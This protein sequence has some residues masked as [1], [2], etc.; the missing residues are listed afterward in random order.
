MQKKISILVFILF[1]VCNAANAQMKDPQDWV[2]YEDVMGVKNGLQHYDYNATLIES[3]APANVFWPGDNINLKF[4]LEN[5]THQTIETDAKIYVFRYGTKGIPNDI[6][7]PQIVKLDYEKVIPARITIS[8]NGYTNTS[9]SID[10][11]KRYGGYAVV[12]D[13]GKYGRR[14]GTSF[15]Y[16]MKP[17]PVKMQYPKQS[18]D[19]LGVD[20][21]SRVGIQS[22]CH[23]IPYVSTASADY[24]VFMQ[25][26]AGLMKKYMDNNI[27]VMLMFGEGRVAPLMPLGTSRPH[28]DESNTFLRTKQDLVWLP[29]MDEDFKKYVKELC[30]KFGWPNGPV[31]A[32]CLWNEPW[33]G[34]SI[35]G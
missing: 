33:E 16:S 31:T 10:D 9:I 21:L 26:F 1:I 8:P 19:D 18:L 3:T 6:W 2:G 28:L 17:S 29:Q 30:L 4:Q 25:D 11:I 20:F 27:T 23:G 22:I 7:L 32:V 13:L 15:V 5:N 14:L 24:Q 34:M 35:S 12:F